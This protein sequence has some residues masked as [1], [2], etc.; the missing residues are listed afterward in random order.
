MEYK[1]YNVIAEWETE[2][3][4]IDGIY[5][6]DF[7]Q[8]FSDTYSSKES[9]IRKAQELASEYVCYVQVKE[10][11]ISEKG[12]KYNKTIYRKH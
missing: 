8:F 11:I 12:M 1:V 2:V 9:A 5:H 7:E 3:P 4:D 6:E 10:V